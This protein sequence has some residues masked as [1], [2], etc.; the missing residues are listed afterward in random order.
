MTDSA[1]ETSE[2]DP[3]FVENDVHRTRLPYD[4]GGVPFYIGLAWAGLIIAYITVMSTVALP[5]LRAWLGR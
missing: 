2:K 5:D 4:T 3:P 1:S